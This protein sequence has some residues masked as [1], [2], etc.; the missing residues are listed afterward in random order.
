MDRAT[1]VTICGSGWPIIQRHKSLVG[2]MGLLFS[3]RM[4]LEVGSRKT[5]R[6]IDSF[7]FSPNLSAKDK[8]DAQFNA[9]SLLANSASNPADFKT[10]AEQSVVLLRETIAA[11]RKEL[12]QQYANES[13][14]AARRSEDQELLRQ[15]TLL[16][17]D[18]QQMDSR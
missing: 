11:N 12:A 1:A 6:S 7:T 2:H 17:L 4:A 5:K 10:I 18:I 15:V 16:I 13:L 8:V 9:L 3:I 14:I